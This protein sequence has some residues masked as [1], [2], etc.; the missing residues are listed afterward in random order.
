MELS[1]NMISVVIVTRDRQELLKR[2]VKSL[3][4]QQYESLEI[5]I[6]DN[7]SVTPPLLEIS[8][9]A[10]VSIKIQRTNQFLSAATTRNLG[11][12]LAT[13][14]YVSF[15]D[16][17]D[18]CLQDKF[19]VL[20]K[21]FEQFEHIKMAY[22]N[23]K[24]LGPNESDLGLCRGPAEIVPLM[25]YRYIHLNSVLIK[26]SILTDY[27]F[28]LN[29]TTYEDVDFIFRIMK[30]NKCIH[31]DQNVAVWNRDNR[32]DQLTSRNWKRAEKNWLILC[33]KFG[34]IIESDYSLANFYYK[35]MFILSAI[36]LNF[37]N[38]IIFFLKYLR[39]AKLAKW[40]K[41]AN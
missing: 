34:Y 15:L 20:L 26:K 39:Y 7:H 21:A 33:K 10:N 32:T 6:I 25:L 36:K 9:P 18:Y 31:V 24:M 38:T 8:I 2:A 4:S 23:T 28:D 3:L 41:Y 22:G 19:S 35:K 11:I 37:Q 16:D 27:R 5:I 12:E 29:M 40:F 1:S 30:D 14:D 17:D 13:G